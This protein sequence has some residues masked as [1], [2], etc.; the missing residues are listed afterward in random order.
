M[1]RE[2]IRVGDREVTF[3][4]GEIAKQASGAALVTA[5]DTVLLVTVSA[6]NRPTSLGY[7][8]LTTEFRLRYSAAGRIPGSYDR[9]EARPSEFE[10]LTSRLVDRSIRPFF[11]DAWC[12]DTQVMIQ[13]LS[14]DPTTDPGVL[15]IAAA[16][17]ALSAS[18]VP[19]AGPVAGVRIART[20]GQLQVMPTPAE[21]KASDLDLVVSCSGDGIVMVEGGG[22][23]IAEDVILE[24]FALAQRHAAAMLRVMAELSA[25]AP[26]K[27]DAPAVEVDGDLA[28]RARELGRGPLTAALAAGK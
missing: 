23:E 22:Q 6:G 1:F 24:A 3:E 17:A 2:T 18:D 4:T 9:R 7:M 8:P 26:A 20:G 10:V 15:G 16:S 13:P 12:Y 5:G 27:R 25:R 19:W 11:D 14:Y 21:Q 28:K